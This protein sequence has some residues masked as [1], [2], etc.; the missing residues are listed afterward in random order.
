M[1]RRET[2]SHGM[3]GVEVI[4][5]PC[6][7]LK[8]RPGASYRQVHTDI[9]HVLADMQFLVEVLVDAVITVVECH[10]GESLQAAATTISNKQI[11]KDL[12]NHS[13][14][15]GPAGPINGGLPTRSH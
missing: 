13:S 5:H 14:F 1:L 6:H 3:V 10:I 7:V 2:Q 12:V 15:P 9:E 4:T 8:T 11:R